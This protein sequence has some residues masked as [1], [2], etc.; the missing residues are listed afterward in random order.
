MTVQRDFCVKNGR[1]LVA[2]LQMLKSCL[3]YAFIEGPKIARIQRSSS[4]RIAWKEDD[5]QYPGGFP[6]GTIG[7]NWVPEGS[8]RVDILQPSCGVE[9][10]YPQ[11]PHP[12][13]HLAS[14]LTAL[15]SL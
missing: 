12:Q 11:P 4:S 6:E 5:Q 3:G 15:T 8:L 1:F 13:L 14:R 7:E 9:S 2:N 10:G